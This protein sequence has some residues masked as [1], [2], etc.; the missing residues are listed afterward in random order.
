[1]SVSVET[2]ESDGLSRLRLRCN[3]DK[4]YNKKEV[5]SAFMYL[6]V[7]AIHIVVVASQPQPQ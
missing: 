4:V 6:T 2:R 7:K 1:M 3:N 5:N